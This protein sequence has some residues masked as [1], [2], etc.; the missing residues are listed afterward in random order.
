MNLMFAGSRQLSQEQKTKAIKIISSILEMA[1][2]RDIIINVGDSDGIDAIVR[3]QCQ[4]Q[5]IQYAVWGVERLRCP[6]NDP[7]KA[8]ILPGQPNLNGFLARD[9]AMIFHCA[10]GIFLSNGTRKYTNGRTTGTIGG[11]EYMLSLEKTAVLI[12]L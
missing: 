4:F 3:S 8:I 7:G 11:Y 12:N 9:R 2:K 10:I 5:K 6:L 1:K